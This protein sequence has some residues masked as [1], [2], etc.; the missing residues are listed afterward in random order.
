M[1]CRITKNAKFCYH[2]PMNVSLTPALEKYIE[3]K[4]TDGS[5]QTASE[6][7]RE[8]LRLL[9]DQDER[10]TLELDR[11]RGEINRGLT[12]VARGEVA[13]LDIKRIK[14]RGR[15]KLAANRLRNVG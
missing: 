14:A 12:Q 1:V 8:A 4:I 15:K 10:R 6:V 3:Q 5:Y 9:A 11:L 7:V 13:P 2:R